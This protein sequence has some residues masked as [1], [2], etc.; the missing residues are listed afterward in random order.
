MEGCD[1][2]WIGIGWNLDAGAMTR[3][4][5]GTENTVLRAERIERTRCEKGCQEYSRRR[6][7]RLVGSRGSGMQE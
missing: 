4:E 6:Q 5:L 7:E 3:F 1:E 2:K